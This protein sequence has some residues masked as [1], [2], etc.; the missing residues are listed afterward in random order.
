MKRPW[1]IGAIALGVVVIVVAVLAVV[2]IGGGQPTAQPDRP[3]L[4]FNEQLVKQ[5]RP[6]PGCAKYP[7]PKPSGSGDVHLGVIRLRGHCLIPE[8]VLV[9]EAE[10]APKLAELR[11]R[12]EVV[13]ADRVDAAEPPAE[14]VDPHPAVDGTEERQWGLDALG[15]ADALRDLWPADAPEIKV[16][17]V[18]SGIDPKQ[19]E[20]ADR[21]A[22]VKDT[23]LGTDGYESHGTEVAGII[24]AADDGTGVTGIAPKAKLLDAQYWRSGEAVGQEGLQD[25]IIWA[26]DQGARVINVSTG[27]TDNS[28]LR[29]AYAYAE[30]SQVVV[31]PAVGNCGGAG[32]GFNWPPGERGYDKDKC[33]RANEIAGGADQPTVLGVGAI[34]E[35]GDR[36]WFSSENRTTMIMAPGENILSTCVTRLAGPRT[37]CSNKGTSFAAPYVSA[38]VA[39][40]LA[41]H[42]EASPADIR[43]ALIMSTDPVDV[44][45]G[46]RNDEYGYGKL[47][48][49]AAAKYLDDHP[50]QPQPEQP[51]I[52]AAARI[53]GKVELIMD[54]GK[55]LEVQ[56]LAEGGTPAF[57]FSADGAWF[58]ATDGKALTVVD[59]YTGRQQSTE[60][61]CSGVA[62]NT[63]SQVLTVQTR[64][65]VKIARYDPMTADWTGATYAPKVSGGLDGAKLVGAAGDVALL[66]LRQGEYANRLIGVWPDSTAIELDGGGL[67]YEQ[68]VGSGKGRF[69]VATSPQSCPR[70]IDLEKSRSTGK[71]WVWQFWPYDD[72][73]CAT[74]ML[75]HFD[76]DTNLELGW[77]AGSMT[78]Q[79]YGCP[80]PA[81][82]QQLPVTGRLEIRPFQPSREPADLPWKDLDC[83]ASGV[84]PSD[85][86]DQLRVRVE[87]PSFESYKYTIVRK[88][89]GGEGEEKLAEH[90]EDVVVRPR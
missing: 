43:Q 51:V 15:G 69:V 32:E 33:V 26:I 47:N 27:A 31:V 36:A 6:D 37:L 61:A 89:A 42:P 78:A 72:F 12:Q 52:R 76:G 40:L 56:Q 84:W 34:N 30:L 50:P 4:P 90:A 64:G 25:E 20:V 44:Q 10:V 67:A 39:I 5:A 38:A 88:K 8:T 24:A 63:K 82:D 62:F 77:L 53:D 55:K 21:M 57:A 23:E 59:A 3:D 18:D 71:P 29:A 87:A 70:V 74:T 81:G 85:T 35:D 66:T 75:A 7:R 45:R 80:K 19:A 41:R 65:G 73:F 28:L 11:Q 13:A 22:G 68:V 9:A 60:C 83:T 2:M 14:V 54:T 1:L 17:V 48:V 16:G 49:I 58:A 79:K 46:Q 86:G